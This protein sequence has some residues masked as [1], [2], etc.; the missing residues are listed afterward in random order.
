MATEPLNLTFDRTA[1]VKT[2]LMAAAFV[3]VFWPVL[4]VLTFYW[5]TSA[6]WSHGWIIPV[7]SA[8]L[9][10]T[11][12]D[13]IR[14]TPIRSAWLGVLVLLFGLGLYQYTLW[15]MK[16]GYVRSVAMLITLLGVLVMTLGLPMLRYLWVPWLYLFFA[17]PLPKGIYFGLTDPL[18]Q[19]AANVATAV[20]GLFQDL[21]I[22]RIGS[23]IEYSYRGSTGQLGVADACSGMR[24]TIT[25]CALGVAVAFMQDRPWWHRLVMIGACIPIAIFANFIRVTTT[26]ILHIF[27]DPRYAAGSFHTALGLVTM[28]IAFGIFMGLAWGLN[29]LHVEASDDEFEEEQAPA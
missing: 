24:S 14:E 21:D 9:V 8:W 27:V 4:A 29:N 1:Q 3:A 17:I 11:K 26:C 2:A 19:L 7:F 25:L 15:G 12:W 28:L 23:T 22:E 18:R 13:Q 16:A 10:Y 20:L 6:D 5:R